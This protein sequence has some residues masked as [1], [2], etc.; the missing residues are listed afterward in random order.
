MRTTQAAGGSGVQV[1]GQQ[2]VQRVGAGEAPVGGVRGMFIPHRQLRTE[3]DIQAMVEI[4]VAAKMRVLYP[5]VLRYSRELFKGAF[6]RYTYKADGSKPALDDEYRAFLDHVK[7]A[8]QG[9]AAG[10]QIEV[11]PWVEMIINA[12][13]TADEDLLEGGKY[14]PGTTPDHQRVLDV[15][16]PG[17]RDLILRQL[18]DLARYDQGS[19]EAIHV[20]DHLSYPPHFIDEAAQAKYVKRMS[21]FV[22]WLIPAFKKAT[23]KVF[24]ISTNKRQWALDK[25]QA[26]WAAWGADRVLVQLY[27]PSAAAI[28]GSGKGSATYQQTHAH[29]GTTLAGIGVTCIAN[30]K[31]VP[32]EDLIK[33]MKLEARDGKSCIV[34]H[35]GD[36][37]KRGPLIKAMAALA[38]GS[39][40]A[41]AG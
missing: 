35:G 37:A 31:A 30:G 10:A 32:D 38:E 41:S 13:T 33:V 1:S 18:V 29:G 40:K 36:L 14:E 9:L 28:M 16:D 6:P 11:I 5:C 26:D 15:S 21:D 17:T 2:I 22:Q 7:A 3:A 25:T 8:N 27:L 4:A 34:W 39:A 23:G 19:A 24:E 20:D 12:R